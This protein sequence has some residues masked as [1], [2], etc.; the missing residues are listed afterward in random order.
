MIHLKANA[1]ESIMFRGPDTITVYLHGDERYGPETRFIEWDISD[2]ELIHY[3]ELELER[4]IN[5]RENITDY[6]NRIKER[7]DCPA[8]WDT[9]SKQDAETRAELDRIAA[10][11]GIHYTD[12]KDNDYV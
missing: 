9:Q 10:E 3:G 2:D 6:V 12:K 1:I 7:C 4:V 11:Q 5:M 8:C